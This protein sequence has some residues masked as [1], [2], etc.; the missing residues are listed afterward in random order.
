MITVIANKEGGVGKTTST[1]NIGALLA[2]AD[3]ACSSSTRPAVRAHPTA[4]TRG[5]IARRKPRRRDG[6][7]RR[8]RRSN[9]AGVYGVEVI[10]GAG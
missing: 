8:R 2:P 7:P 1:A 5:P 3:D 4:R 10:P 9:R 6:R